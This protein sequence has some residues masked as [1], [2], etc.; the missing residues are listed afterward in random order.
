VGTFWS[1]RWEDNFK[2]DIRETGYEH[3]DWIQLYHCTV[4]RQTFEKLARILMFLK[5][6]I[7]HYRLSDYGVFE[8]YLAPCQYT[9]DFLL[10]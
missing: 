9:Y 2:V 6:R 3:V 1:P 7:F 8:D 10:N 4:Q 5:G